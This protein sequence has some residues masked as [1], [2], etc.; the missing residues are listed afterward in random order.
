MLISAGKITLNRFTFDIE[1]FQQRCDEY[2]IEAEELLD[3]NHL[4]L[5][6][7]KVPIKLRGESV[8]IFT[9]VVIHPYYY[10]N[11]VELVTAI[12]ITKIMFIS[13][14]VA[15]ILA[16]AIFTLKGSIFTCI[17]ILAALSL[18]LF[19]LLFKSVKNQVLKKVKALIKQV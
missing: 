11:K 19:F 1:K 5:F 9:K 4:K 6:K 12:N 14:G 15:F 10:K 3:T 13:V 8:M 18:T 17:T 7:L 2:P 16:F